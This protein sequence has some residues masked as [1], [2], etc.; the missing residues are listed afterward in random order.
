VGLAAV[1]V[2]V[3]RKLSDEGNLQSLGSSS[4][5]SQNA[6]TRFMVVLCF[7]FGKLSSLFAY[8]SDLYDIFLSSDLNSSFLG[9]NWLSVPM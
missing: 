9:M 5:A 1:A 6:F 2:T 4:I 3:F 8:P 7:H